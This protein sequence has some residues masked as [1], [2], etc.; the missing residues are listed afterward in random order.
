MLAAFLPPCLAPGQGC[1][2]LAAA[3]PY[4]LSALPAHT[5]YTGRLLTVLPSRLL[6]WPWQDPVELSSGAGEEA[7]ALAVNLRASG[8]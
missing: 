3:W 7:T 5:V 2:K 1:C 6:A 4:C 8:A